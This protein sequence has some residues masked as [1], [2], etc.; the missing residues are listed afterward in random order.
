MIFFYIKN[1]KGYLYLG[2]IVYKSYHRND[3]ATIREKQAPSSDAAGM[4][5][6]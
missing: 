2:A 6:T 1:L 5:V 4:A 3:A